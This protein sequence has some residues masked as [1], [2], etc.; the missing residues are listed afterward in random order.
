MS[1]L[2]YTLTTKQIVFKSPHSKQTPTKP[3]PMKE[4]I[5]E[6][7]DLLQIERIPPLL[8]SDGKNTQSQS[9]DPHSP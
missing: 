2:E 9:Q 3:S 8:P 1:H 7:L 6:L 5:R 4:K